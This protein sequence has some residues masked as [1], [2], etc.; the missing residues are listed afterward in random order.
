MHFFRLMSRGMPSQ[1]SQGDTATLH[2]FHVKKN[3]S[4]EAAVVI[5]LSYVRRLMNIVR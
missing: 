4:P 2:L 1:V 3:R 5:L